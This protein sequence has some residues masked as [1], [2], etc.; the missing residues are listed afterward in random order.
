MS[1]GLIFWILMILWAISWAA[2]RWGQPNQYPWMIHASN[3]LF[4]ILLFLLGWR[5][6]GFVVQGGGGG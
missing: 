1:I 6:F 3:L 2:G 5:V 4:F